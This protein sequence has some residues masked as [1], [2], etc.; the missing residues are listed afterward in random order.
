MNL[1]ERIKEDSSFLALFTQGVSSLYKSGV[2][3]F[4]ARVRTLSAYRS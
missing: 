1:L 3:W 4:L 2:F